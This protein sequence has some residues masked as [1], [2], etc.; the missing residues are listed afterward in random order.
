MD[1]R[2]RGHC[3]MLACGYAGVLWAGFAPAAVAQTRSVAQLGGFASGAQISPPPVNTGREDVFARPG[4]AEEALIVGD[5]LIYPSVFA[6]GVYDSNVNQS[7]SGVSSG[8]FRVA[9]SIT[10]ESNSG[11]FKTTLY[12]NADGRF[13]LRNIPNNSTVISARAGA[14]EIYA[15]FPD[16]IVTGQADYTRQQDL[17]STLGNTSGLTSL[18]PT[19]IGLSPTPNPTSYDQLS[20]AASVQKNFARSF[21]T[22][23]GSLVDIDYDRI[24]GSTAPSPGGTTYTAG[25][26]GGLWITPALYG[27][28]EG[29]ADS[30]DYG[31][32]GSSGHRV[33]GGVGTDQIGLF[34]G[35][36]FAGY[37]REDYNSSAI[38][39]KDGGVYGLAGHYYPLPEMTVNV[40]ANETL[41]VSQLSAVAGAP[42]SST[43]VDTVLLT[44][45]YTLFEQ[46]G[47]NGRA[48]Y[49]RT[50]YLDAGRR[51]IAWTIGGT[52]TY[53]LLR[54][55]GL[56]L[57]YQH[58][59][60]SSNA[61]GQ[62]FSRDIVSIGAT[63]RY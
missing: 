14:T 4:R 47:A 38:G 49:I 15:P 52:L 24:S 23:G 54:N 39:T 40:S 16:L 58:V 32:L 62:D 10:A 31:A 41:G 30:R 28:V 20:G 46:W 27:Y 18:N 8:G 1:W 5:W 35:E 37:Q 57:D 33:V 60:L 59:D 61:A 53:Q 26:R 51:D 63:Y 50:E 7:S 43:R 25:L 22:F 17:F 3:A 45:D 56:T 21:V 12:G 48:G 19:G 42:G 11:L 29:A 55:V 6:G 2:V 34:K 44:A 9:P 36:V 13:Y